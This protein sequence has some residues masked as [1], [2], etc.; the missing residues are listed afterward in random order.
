MLY[1]PFLWIDERP[2]KAQITVHVAV[3][4]PYVN[5]HMSLIH[6]ATLLSTAVSVRDMEGG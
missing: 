2:N 1:S 5:D 6:L 3:F 4:V